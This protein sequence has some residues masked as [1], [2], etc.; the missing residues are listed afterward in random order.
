M[1]PIWSRV[2][3]GV[4]GVCE[5]GEGVGKG[6]RGKCWRGEREGRGLR[7]KKKDQG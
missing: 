4:G 5:R 1:L 6:E 7:E 3:W 2:E